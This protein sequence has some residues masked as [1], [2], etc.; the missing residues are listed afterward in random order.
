ME[1]KVPNVTILVV[2]IQS[3]C[4][5]SIM[6]LSLNAIC[7]W[8]ASTQTSSALNQSDE[9]MGSDRY[10][11]MDRAKGNKRACLAFIIAVFALGVSWFTRLSL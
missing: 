4:A 7:H 5:L 10:N 9:D 2:W 11:E 8:H 3:L 6:A 1:N